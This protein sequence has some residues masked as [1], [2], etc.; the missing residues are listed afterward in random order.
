MGVLETL[1]AISIGRLILLGILGIIALALFM[2][3]IVGTAAVSGGGKGWYGT[4]RTEER[5][6]RRPMEVSTRVIGWGIA[7]VAFGLGILAGI[8]GVSE[9]SVWGIAGMALLFGGI[10]LIFFYFIAVRRERISGEKVLDA[11][12]EE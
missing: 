6:T 8:Y 3:I 4:R 2:C 12:R 7:L 1:A 5:G 11:E 10:G 9:A